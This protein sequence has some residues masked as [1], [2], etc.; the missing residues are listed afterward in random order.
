MIIGYGDLGDVV[1]M[2]SQLKRID[3]RM[4]GEELK[5]VNADNSFEEIF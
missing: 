4:G 1:Q 5:A 3:E 2:K